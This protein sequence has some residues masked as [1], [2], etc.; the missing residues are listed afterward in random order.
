MNYNERQ[1]Y[2]K[3]RHLRKK[4]FDTAISCITI[5]LHLEMVFIPPPPIQCCTILKLIIWGIENLT[6]VGGREGGGIFCERG[7]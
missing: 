7:L 6:L 1:N 5:Y 3:L 2:M 4:A